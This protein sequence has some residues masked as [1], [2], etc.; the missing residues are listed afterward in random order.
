MSKKKFVFIFVILITVALNVIVIAKVDFGTVYSNELYVC[1][2][3]ESSRDNGIQVFYD[4]TESYSE[5]KSYVIEY[6]EKDGRDTLSFPIKPGNNSIRIDFGIYESKVCVYDI[7]YKC[8]GIKYAI[9][10]EDIANTGYVTDISS[11]KIE[12]SKLMIETVDGDSNIAYYFEEDVV[13]DYIN[14]ELDKKAGVINVIICVALD[15]L[16]LF[17]LLKF[18][19]NIEIPADIYRERKLIATL[20]K[21]DFKTRFAGSYMGIAWAFIQ[22]IATILVYWFVFEQGLR[23]GR[24]CDY[25][26]ILWFMCGLVPWFYFSD[27]INGGTNALLE[28]NY[29]VKKVVFKITILPFVKVI[30]NVFIHLFFVAFIMVLHI[31]YGYGPDLYWVQIIYYMLCTIVLVLG[32]SYLTS[33]LVVFFRDLTQIIAILLQIGMWATPIMWDVNQFSPQLKL[34][35]KTN[36]VYYIVEG[37]RNALLGDMWFWEDMYWTMYFWIIT[38]VLFVIGQNIFRKL[39]IHFADVL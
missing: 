20:A 12:N 11:I 8:A 18:S 9:S 21:N 38:V 23:A 30:S 1:I 6:Y 25:P 17:I 26:F 2:D 19:S 36:P 10:M 39:R 33:A 14:K 34:F 24:M 16:V 28:Y 35:F 5:D 15:L 37:Y 32:L 3:M 13:T 31:I 7:Y 22:P 27:A 29:L 4:G